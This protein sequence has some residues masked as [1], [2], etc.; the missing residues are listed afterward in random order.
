MD[1]EEALTESEDCYLTEDDEA[2]NLRP[3][4]DKAAFFEAT[5]QDMEHEALDDLAYS[6][7][8]LPLEKTI[9]DEH[10]GFIIRMVTSEMSARMARMEK[11]ANKEAKRLLSPFVPFQL[12]LMFSLYRQSF[13]KRP[14]FLY[15]CSDT[16]N[17]YTMWL[18]PDLPIYTADG[19]DERMLMEYPEAKRALL[20][21]YIAEY[22]RTERRRTETEFRISNSLR[23]TNLQK[24]TYKELYEKRPMWFKALYDNTLKELKELL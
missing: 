24:I 12:R 14:S 5:R 20:E 2:L 11:L 23:Q 3:S 16:R 15:H 9:S 6:Q 8:L 10:I 17:G 7:T 13:K 19:E 21:L 18:S 1:I 4:Q 22:R